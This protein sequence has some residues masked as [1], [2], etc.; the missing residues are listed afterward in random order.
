MPIQIPDIGRNGLA[1]LFAELGFKKGVE[2]GVEEGLYSEVLC[3]SNPDLKLYS[4]DAWQAYSDYKDHTRQSK[5][6]RFYETAKERLAPYNCELM[7]MFSLDAVH[8]FKNNSLDF[9]YIDGNHDFYNCTAD[10]FHWTRKVRDGGIIAGHDWERHPYPNRIH[11]VH[12]TTGYT[13]AY[14]IRPWFVLSNKVIVDDQIL[15]EARSFLWVKQPF[16]TPK[17][18]RI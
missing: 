18:H 7:R 16:E 13:A 11:V 6:D 14:N 5:L 3:K 10:I 2:I 9:V 15:D 4:V 12:A 17:E 8:H 1:N